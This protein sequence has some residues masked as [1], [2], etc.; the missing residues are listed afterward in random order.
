MYEKV[1]LAA[2]SFIVGAAVVVLACAVAAAVRRRKRMVVSGGT[3]GA[4]TGVKKGL[5]KPKTSTVSLV[6]VAAYILWF[7]NR[8]IG[9]YETTGAI[10]DTLVTC[11]FAICGG[12][13]GALGW[14]RTSKEKY[15]DRKW[16]MED[17]KRMNEAAEKAAEQYDSLEPAFTA[18][19]RK[20]RER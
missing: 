12:E 15:R 10:P 7:T 11:V 19:S 3:E 8:M 20:M 14:I 2:V 6:V 13:C 16:G 4:H 9:L 5:K 18:E 1:L 17:E